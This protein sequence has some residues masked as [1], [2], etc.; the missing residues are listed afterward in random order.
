M[1]PGCDKSSTIDYL[2]SAT[3][4]RLT[5]RCAAFAGE[6]DVLTVLIHQDCPLDY[7]GPNLTGFVM[8]CRILFIF[9]RAGMLKNSPGFELFTFCLPCP[10]EVVGFQVKWPKPRRFCAVYQWFLI[11]LIG[12]ATGDSVPKYFT[13]CCYLCIHIEFQYCVSGTQKPMVGQFCFK[14]W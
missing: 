5:N 1:A 2:I 14:Y 7:L 12:K 4:W 6:I 9:H 8:G 13:L 3:V 10:V 11:F